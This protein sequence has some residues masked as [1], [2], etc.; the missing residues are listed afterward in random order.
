VFD[1]EPDAVKS[2]KIR[3][4]RELLQV[5]CGVFFTINNG[6]LCDDCARFLR[7]DKPAGIVKTDAVVDAEGKKLALVKEVYMRLFHEM[8]IS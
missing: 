2:S 7:L 1:I 6:N 5:V 3:V 4:L 8:A